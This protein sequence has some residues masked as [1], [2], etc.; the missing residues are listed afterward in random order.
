M[1]SGWILVAYNT[2]SPF[3]WLIR[4]INTV[5]L[6]IYNIIYRRFNRSI[7]FPSC[8]FDSPQ[9]V[10]FYA[11]FWRIP[12]ITQRACPWQQ[13]LFNAKT[14]QAKISFTASHLQSV[15]ITSTTIQRHCIFLTLP[16]SPISSNGFYWRD[17]SFQILL[18]HSGN[19]HTILN[20]H[21][22]EFDF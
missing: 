6:S 19:F 9:N 3:R 5:F 12:T 22:S 20:M 17:W 21:L 11:C 16:L 7:T 1:R 10:T 15:G 4:R 8:F 18:V 13:A 14:A 2:F